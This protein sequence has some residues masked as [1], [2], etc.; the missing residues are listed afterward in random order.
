MVLGQF[1]ALD[2]GE[3]ADRPDRMLVD[4]IM[5]IHVELHLGDDAPEVRHEAPEHAGL[6]HPS[7]H[8]IGPLAVGQHF[9]EESVG[10]R[11]V[12]NLVDQPNV[13]GRGAH[14]ARVDLQPFAGGDGEQLDQPD[15]LLGQEALVG[16]RKPPPVQAKA[17]QFRRPLQEGRQREAA[18]LAAHLLVELGQ[19]LAGEV[20]DRFRL[21]EVELHEPLDRRLA[22]PLGVAQRPGDRRLVVEAEALLGAAGGQMQLAAD[23]PEK[24][25]GAFEPAN[26]LAVNR[27]ESTSS[28]GRL[29]PY[30]YW[31]IQ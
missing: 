20:A 26:S 4:R 30:R 3:Q 6:V 28:A 7:Q 14:R 23:R 12:A 31:P 9:Q 15:R 22:G 17:V 8:R 10:L 29:I 5:V 19:E 25:L 24:A 21:Q 18:A 11:V 13:V 16:N 2:G 27:P 1:A